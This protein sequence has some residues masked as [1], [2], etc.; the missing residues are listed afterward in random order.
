MMLP[1]DNRSIPLVCKEETSFQDGN[2]AREKG[3]V[4][5]L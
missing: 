4:V 1:P 2:K 5:L 3:E